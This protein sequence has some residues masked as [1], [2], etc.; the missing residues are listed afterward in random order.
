VLPTL[1]PIVVL[2]LATA[3]FGNEIEDHTLP[4]LTMKPIGRWRIVL[5]KWAAIVLVA[6]PV[7]LLGLALAAAVASRRPADTA[8]RVAAAPDVWPLLGAMAASTVV[9][10]ALLSSVFLAVSL[11]VPRALLAGMVYVFAWESLLG[12][13][14]PGVKSASIRHAAESVFVAVLADPRVTVED[15][16][17]IRGAVAVAAGVS[18]AALALAVV[19]LRTMNQ[20]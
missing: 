9:G 20:E 17:T 4:Y 3:A 14:L 6:L 19:R 8:S 5:E 2:L 18:L 15:G 10:V 11:L 12:R 13:L 1:L 7:L 16:A